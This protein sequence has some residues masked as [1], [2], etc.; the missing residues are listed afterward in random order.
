[1]YICICIVFIHLLG[2]LEPRHLLH[3]ALAHGG[4]EAPLHVAPQARV[5]STTNTN[6]TTNNNNNTSNHDI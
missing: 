6:T 2:L 3:R 5:A 1:M 4:A